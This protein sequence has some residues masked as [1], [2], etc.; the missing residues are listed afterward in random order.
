MSMKNGLKAEIK[1]MK[2][3][4]ISEKLLLMRQSRLPWC[5]KSSHH[6]KPLG[7]QLFTLSAAL[8]K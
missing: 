4:M 7:K 3:Q 2:E 8:S 5:W 1:L 6:S